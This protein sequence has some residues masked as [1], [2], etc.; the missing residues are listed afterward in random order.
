MIWFDLRINTV[1]THYIMAFYNRHL[2]GKDNK[3]NTTI[4]QYMNTK[5][6]AV[7]IWA[8]QLKAVQLKAA[9]KRYVF[10]LDLKMVSVSADVH[11]LGSLFQSVGAY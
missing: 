9:A 1:K 10:S 2:K 7:W 6:T 4:R 3:I 8:V 11:D 5:Q